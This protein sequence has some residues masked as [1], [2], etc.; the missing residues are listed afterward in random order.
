MKYFGIITVRTS[1]SRLKQKCLLSFGR[2]KVIEHVIKRCIKSNIIPILCTT[3]EKADKILVQIA[4]KFNIKYFRG[5]NNNKIKRWFDCCKKYKINAFHTIDADDPFFDP[6]AVKKSLSLLNNSKYDII[7]PSEISKNG[8]ASEGY[9]FKFSAINRLTNL[10]KKKFNNYNK[11][12]TE[13]IE[14]FINEKNFKIK[15]FSGMKYQLRKVRLTLD[16]FED[17]IMLDLIRRSFKNY[18][19]ERQKI[20]TFLSKNKNIIK[21]N[22]FRNSEWK[23]RQNKLLKK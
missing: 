14:R 9:S 6:K 8:A 18:Y 5:S 23:S 16:Y 21:I 4:K 12:D 10:I 2:I 20:N 7:Y 11:L 1:S 3:R 15:K 13:M 19:I 22:Y 17:Y